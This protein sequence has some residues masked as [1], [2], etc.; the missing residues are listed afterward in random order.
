MENP[1][2]IEPVSLYESVNQ[3][4]AMEVVKGKSYSKYLRE[5]LLQVV[6]LVSCKDDPQAWQSNLD[7]KSYKELCHLLHKDRTKPTP[8]DDIYALKVKTPDGRYITRPGY[9]LEI[10]EALGHFIECENC[11]LIGGFYVCTLNDGE[12]VQ[13]PE[14]NSWH[15][16]KYTDNEPLRRFDEKHGG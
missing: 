5:K 4:D 16:D 10:N 1:K 2:F 9:P 12:Q 15:P 11:P 3:V 14:C 13:C 8:S 6:E 7:Y